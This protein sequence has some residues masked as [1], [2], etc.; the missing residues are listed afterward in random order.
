MTEMKTR[1]VTLV[2]GVVLVAITTAC[3]GASGSLSPTGPS[4]TSGSST[5]ITG[6]VSGMSALPALAET[7]GPRA[8]TSIKVTISG[9]DVSTMVDGTGNF[10][11]TGVPP[12]T[13]TLQFSGTGISATLTLSG[14]AA[15]DKV[16]IEVTLTGSG[17]RVDSESR[18]HNDNKRELEGHIT[19]VD[20]GARTIK[21]G[22]TLVSVPDGTPIRSGG[23]T[24]AFADLKVGQEVEVHGALDG[25][26]FKATDVNV[27]DDDDENDDDLAEAKGSVAG[28][29]GTCPELTFTIGDRT[30][31]TT[32]ATRF[33]EGCAQVKNTV[34]VEVKGTIG[35]DKVLTA[36]RVELDD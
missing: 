23:K 1:W 33:D 13:V 16:H 27:E 3:G 14:I 22:T 4:A 15:G 19:A 26:T 12:G 2:I 29:T 7:F 20:P 5:V 36:S 31:K 21:V 34:R 35:T 17:A 10:T 30:V 8:A 32:S 24:I 25:T 18:E 28:L 9:T 6:R 11:L